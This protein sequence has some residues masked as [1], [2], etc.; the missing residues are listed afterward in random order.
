MCEPGGHSSGDAFPQYLSS[1]YH[2]SVS[3]SR[4]QT[5]RQTASRRSDEVLLRVDRLMCRAT[6]VIAGLGSC[7]HFQDAIDRTSNSVFSRRIHV[8]VSKFTAFIHCLLVWQ[9]DGGQEEA[10]LTLGSSAVN[11]RSSDGL[12]PALLHL[13]LRSLSDIEFVSLGWPQD[14]YLHQNRRHF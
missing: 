4:V 14:G 9:H 7:S 2:H 5:S 11:T 8:R 1:K 12:T 10:V 6:E 13:H 3:V